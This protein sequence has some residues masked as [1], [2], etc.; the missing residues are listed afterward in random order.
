MESQLRVSL[1]HA[2][3]CWLWARSIKTLGNLTFLLQTLPQSLAQN[4]L[5]FAPETS[6]LPTTVLGTFWQHFVQLYLKLLILCKSDF[7]SVFLKK[8]P[9]SQQPRNMKSLTFLSFFPAATLCFAYRSVQIA[10]SYLFLF[11][12]FYPLEN[13]CAAQQCTGF[14]STCAEGWKQRAKCAVFRLT[15]E[16]ACG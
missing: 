9:V 10:Q 15:V 8:K 11:Y 5:F 7:N 2:S 14:S 3:P 6:R 13:V 1:L 12:F 4:F 16:R